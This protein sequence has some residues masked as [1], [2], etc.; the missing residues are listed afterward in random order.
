MHSFFN[1]KGGFMSA[2]IFL[3]VGNRTVANALLTAATV[4]CVSACASF[5]GRIAPHFSLEEVADNI[6]CEL[7]EA[8]LEQKKHFPWLEQWAASFTLTL[9]RQDKVGLGPKFEYLEKDVFGLGATGEVSTDAIRSLTTKRTLALKNLEAH[10][11]KRP[12]AGL[13]TGRLG[14]RESL[15][16]ALRV[17]GKGDAI[18]ETPEDLGY[19]IDFAIKAAAG[20]SPSWIF[21]RIPGVGFGV[22]GSSETTHTLDIA[23]ADNTPKG[24]QKV[25]VVNSPAGW[26]QCDA[27]PRPPAVV[28]P[29]E[30][31]LKSDGTERFR[32]DRRRPRA[33][34]T[35]Q[36]KQQLD[37]TLF[38]M[39]LQ[40]LKIRP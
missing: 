31:G 7:Q 10:T 12:S 4:L 30:A 36:A 24:P 9:K 13:L 40:N 20:V 11:C 6:Q 25:C 18:D 21:T 16:E 3:G 27:K 38:R 15:H 8:Y 1:Y 28:V 19:H 26:T 32:K 22:S 23:F 29:P 5:E 33:T 37:G 2:R 39:Q 17:R 34:V 35:P 14:L